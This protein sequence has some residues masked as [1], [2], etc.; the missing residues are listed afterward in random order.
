MDIRLECVTT[1]RILLCRWTTNLYPSIRSSPLA[2]IVI[3]CET[4]VVRGKVRVF[5]YFHPL[6][7]IQAWN[8]S[9][10]TEIRVP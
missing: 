8:F 5:I 3:I 6:D 9:M 4:L 2:E 1:A 7:S 10:Y